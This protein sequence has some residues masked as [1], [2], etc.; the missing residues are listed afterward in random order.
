MKLEKRISLAIL[1]LV[2]S[3]VLAACANQ[4]ETSSSAPAFDGNIDWDLHGVWVTVDG[5]VLSDQEGVDFSLTGTLPTEYDLY[6]TVEMELDFAWPSYLG[7]ENQ[8]KQIYVGG[9]SVA[10]KHNNEPIY[11][12]AGWIQGSDSISLGFTICPDLGYV[13]VHVGDRYLAAS[14]EPDANPESIMDFYKAYVQVN[15]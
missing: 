9:A 3:L 12:G 1:F 15:S 6:D 10:N 11:H 14:T 7:Y 5:T 2:L 4:G 13:I 8:G